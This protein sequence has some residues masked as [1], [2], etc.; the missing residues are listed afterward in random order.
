MTQE[1]LNLD[2][3]H[4]ARVYSLAVAYPDDVPGYVAENGEI[5][6]S[7]GTDNSFGIFFIKRLRARALSGP[8][9]DDVYN[10]AMQISSMAGAPELGQ[11]LANEFMQGRTDMM[12]LARYLEDLIGVIPALVQ[13]NANSYQGTSL[14]GAM[15]FVWQSAAGLMPPGLLQKLQKMTFELNEWYVN[16]LMD[17]V[18][19]DYLE[20]AWPRT[21]KG[22][23]DSVEKYKA[24]KVDGDGL[25]LL[26]HCGIIVGTAT[27]FRP[28]LGLTEDDI[29]SMH[30]G[31]NVDP[32]VEWLQDND[33][34]Q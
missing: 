34:I 30:S 18:R 16:S 20:S 32:L 14:Y 21:V 22:L 9:R 29:D 31:F 4:L 8:A 3:A 25:P 28:L 17:A 26:V 2:G 19:L 7:E 10:E 23:E 24:A 1:N 15:G 13:G 12:L 6:K 27:A 5:L 11:Q 33:W